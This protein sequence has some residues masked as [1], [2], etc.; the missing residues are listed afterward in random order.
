MALAA[1]PSLKER[2]NLTNAQSYYAMLFGVPKVIYA[3]TVQREDSVKR[4]H[5]TA[6][7]R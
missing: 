2:F 4:I 3:R 6:K 1:V 5:L 7:D